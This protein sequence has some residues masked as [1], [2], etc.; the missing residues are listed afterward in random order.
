MFGV[1]GLGSCGKRFEKLRMCR[2]SWGWGSSRHGRIQLQGRFEVPGMFSSIERRLFE[3]LPSPDPDT[4]HCYA[5]RG[6]FFEE[7]WEGSY[8]VDS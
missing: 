2:G 1:Q 6:F 7:R 3:H 5:P 8:A 4:L